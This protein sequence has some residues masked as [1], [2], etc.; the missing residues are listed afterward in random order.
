MYSGHKFSRA[1]LSLIIA[2]TL[3]LILNPIISQAGKQVKP[4]FIDIV[5]MEDQRQSVSNLFPSLSSRA[6]DVRQRA[7]L[8]IGRIAAPVA[9]GDEATEAFTALNTRLQ[10]DRNADVRQAAAFSLG[11]LG[12]EKA[13]AA[14]AAHLVRGRERKA[15]VRQTTIEALGRTASTLHPAAYQ[16]SLKDSDDHVVQAALLGV[17]KGS[18]LPHLSLILELSSSDNCIIRWSATYALMR[19]LGARPAGRTAIPPG[20]QLLDSEKETI[21]ARMLELASDSEIQVRL[22]A[23]RALGAEVQDAELSARAIVALSAG[24]TAVDAR[25]RV[26][27]IRSLGRLY[28]NSGDMAT[29][30]PFLNDPHPHVRIEAIRAVGNIVQPPALPDVLTQAFTSSLAWERAVAVQVACDAY[31]ENKLYQQALHL[32][33]RFQTDSDWTV[34]YASAVSLDGLWRSLYQAAPVDE[35]NT[36]A[37]DAT[38]QCEI[39]ADP[40]LSLFK[41]LLDSFINDDPKVAKGIVYVYMMQGQQAHTD[42]TAWL[43]W[44]ESMLSHDDEMIRTLV[45]DGLREDIEINYIGERLTRTITDLLRLIPGMRA[46]ESPDVRLTSVALLEQML[47]AEE[48][49]VTDLPSVSDLLYDIAREDADRTVR[50]EA[51]RVLQDYQATSGSNSNSER[52]TAL[53]PGPQATPWSRDDYQQA[54]EKA[55]RA[56]AALIQTESGSLRINLFGEDA[57]LTVNNFITLAESG[58][59]NEGAWHRVVPDFVVQD[60]CP[61]TDGW[62]GPGYA[63]RCEYNQHHYQPGALGMALSGKDTGGSQYFLTLSDQPHLDGRYT[64][65]GFLESGWDVMSRITQ[66]ESITSITIEY[67]Q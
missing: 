19:C 1:T 14:L 7:C 61:R 60:G 48:L 45:I 64:I 51:I 3:L 46:D 63:I 21:I 43:S 42:Y 55:R 58:Y 44:I 66:G 35:D 52:I 4:E 36:S 12:D 2:V 8:A 20:A 17:W 22:Q 24:L 6:A 27:A 26:E 47:L 28:A 34:R 13:A 18:I 50:A 29:V 9:P 59:Y 15:A 67:A 33:T 41:D 23:L 39:S 54:I 53:E 38:A 5:Q 16:K 10:K 57:P 31:Q 56:Q 40:P 62:G 30:E 37:A 65:F 32:I 25:E 49:P 11:L